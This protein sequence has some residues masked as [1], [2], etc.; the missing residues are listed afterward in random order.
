GLA[1]LVLE[2]RGAIDEQT[3]G[4]EVGG[5]LGEEGLHLGV[6]GERRA[7][8]DARLRVGESLVERAAAHADRGGADGGTED[9]ERAEGELEAVAFLAEPLRYGNSGVVVTKDTHGVRGVELGEVGS[10]TISGDEQA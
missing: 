10:R 2:P 5:G 3:R 4:L 6:V 9:V 7:E 8:L 1:L